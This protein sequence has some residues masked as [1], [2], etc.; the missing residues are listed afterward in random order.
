MQKPTRTEGVESARSPA[1][2][3]EALGRLLRDPYGALLLHW[4]WKSALF[5][6]LC[7]SVIFF[8]ATLHAGMH[9]ATSAMPTEFLYRGLT[10]GFHGAITQ[11]FSVVS[12]PR[13]IL[14]V[15]VAVP[16]L[17]HAIEFAVHRLRGT[18]GLRFSML[19]S[20][21][22]TVIT[23][24][25]NLYAMRHGLLRVGR[26][27]LSLGADLR[28]LPRTILSFLQTGLGLLPARTLRSHGANVD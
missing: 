17:S 15:T 11:A 26:G 9:A 21:L 2:L 19:A 10:A 24:L 28:R 8:V 25:F 6:S 27:S 20:I 14:T 12:T 23:T 4:N 1:T 7:R 3:S 16:A 5:S 18:P 13:A 22:F